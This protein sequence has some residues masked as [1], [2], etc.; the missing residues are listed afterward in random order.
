MQDGSIVVL[1]GGREAVALRVT[2]VVLVA[3]DVALAFQAAY[4]WNKPA[5]NGANVC[6]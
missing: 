2:G 4:P 5:D 6:K 3:A 1:V